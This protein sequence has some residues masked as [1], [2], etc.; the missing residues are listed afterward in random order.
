VVVEP[1]T[2]ED[3]SPLSDRLEHWDPYTEVEVFR[4]VDV[5]T[6]TVRTACGL[7]G[8]ASLALATSWTSSR[9]RLGASGEGVEFADRRGVLR[10]TVSLT[11][12][13]PSAGG[14]LDLRTTLV[15]RAPGSTASAVSPRRE[16]AILW[17]DEQRVALEGA[18]ARFPV[19]AV[20]FTTIPR[21]PDDGS[22]SL[23]WDGQDL[24]DPVLAAMRLIVNSEDP[25]L[26]EALRSGSTDP[27]SAALRSFVMFD[28]ARS[29]VHAAL[30]DD[31]FVEEP[32]DFS[33]DS[34]GRMLFELL[35]M[36]W[37]GVPIRA[38]ATR[39]AEDPTRLDTELQ[40]RL[41]VFR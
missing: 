16:G 36:N 3:G 22:W 17:F 15:L 37:P 7:G 31:R 28:V 19:A 21:L 2:T 9:S 33:E 5:N 25:S 24:G 32:E 30:R 18:A 4:T 29:M 20:D 10:S 26:L 8:D 34:V 6:D 40:A 35:S 11:V 14:R 13:G 23:E 27:R 39:L 41:G 38:L 1:W 12:P